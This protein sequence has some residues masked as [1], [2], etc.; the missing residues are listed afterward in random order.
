MIAEL[1]ARFARWT[2]TPECAPW[3]SP[4]TAAFCA[5]A[6]LNWMKKMAG[7]SFE[8]NRQDAMAWPGCCTPA[9]DVQTTVARVHGPAFAAAWACCRPATWPWHRRSGVLPVEVKLGLVPRPSARSAR[10]HGQRAAQRYFL[11]AERF[12]AGRRIAS[13]CAGADAA[14]RARRQDQRNPGPAGAGGPA[15]LAAT[16]DLVRAVAGRPVDAALIADTATR[17]AGRAPRTK[18]EGVRSFLEKRKPAWHPGASAR[19]KKTK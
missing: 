17:I 11:T 15:S 7:Y 19:A 9:H 18:Q 4:G 3:C 8:E 13:A 12:S 2:R 5:G 1:T 16:K 14:R 10:G 6:D